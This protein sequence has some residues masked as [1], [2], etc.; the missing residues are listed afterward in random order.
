MTR[1][2]RKRVRRL[3]AA[4]ARVERIR[5]YYPSWDE[6]TRYARH[7]RRVRRYRDALRCA[8]FV[9][10]QT[11]PELLIGFLGSDTDPKIREFVLLNLGTT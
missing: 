4:I 7:A 5:W 2:A 8:R 9:L 3:N 1:A 11:P 6:A 10:R